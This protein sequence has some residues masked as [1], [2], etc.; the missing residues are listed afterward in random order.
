MADLDPTINRTNINDPLPEQVSQLVQ[1]YHALLQENAELR[2]LVYSPEQQ[3][4]HQPAWNE[5]DR[6]METDVQ[7]QNPFDTMYNYSPNT[8]PALYPDED[9]RGDQQIIERRRLNG[10]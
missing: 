7:E 1:Q 8:W 9:E 5:L 4:R 10:M 6:L 2:S 3:G